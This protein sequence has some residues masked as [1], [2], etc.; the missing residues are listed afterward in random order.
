MET[1]ENKWTLQQL[2]TK[3]N[4]LQNVNDDTDFNDED[5]YQTKN[6]LA[7]SVPS[8]EEATKNNTATA[9]QMITTTLQ[10]L[11]KSN[12]QLNDELKSQN[13]M[14]LQQQEE[15]VESKRSMEGELKAM[16]K[17]LKEQEEMIEIEVGALYKYN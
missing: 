10:Q 2:K 7:N 17:R 14:M 1:F 6:E 5:E 15:S 9:L 11:Q 16:S 3:W 4:E 8:P 12:L 13:K